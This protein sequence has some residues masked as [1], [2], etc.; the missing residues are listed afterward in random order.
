[1]NL[2]E[3]M[4]PMEEAREQQG[5]IGQGNSNITVSQEPPNDSAETAASANGPLAPALPDLNLVVGPRQQIDPVPI[6]AHENQDNGP[7]YED[8]SLVAILQQ[9]SSEPIYSAEDP[10]QLEVYNVVTYVNKQICPILATSSQTPPTGGT[11]K[12]LQSM[13]TRVVAQN[14]DKKLNIVEDRGIILEENRV[15]P[16]V[17]HNREI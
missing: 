7:L 14:I 10:M 6:R 3:I 9:H 2:N 17:E 16:A 5:I 8:P 1:M 13:E 11:S 15:L 12:L 4:E